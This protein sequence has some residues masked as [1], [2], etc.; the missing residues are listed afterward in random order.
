MVELIPR[1]TGEN[2]NNSKLLLLVHT[3]REN[4]FRYR[5]KFKAIS[6][7]ETPIEPINPILFNG[8]NILFLPC[9]F[10]VGKFNLVIFFSVYQIETWQVI[11]LLDRNQVHYS[12]NRAVRLTE[13]SVCYSEWVNI[14]VS[15]RGFIWGSSH[16]LL[17]SVVIWHSHFG[18]K[19]GCC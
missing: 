7:G 3:R 11:C 5:G 18:E 14:D 10:I 8:L 6:V 12:T 16:I 2:I 9:R 1:E 17:L 15:N 4:Q 19:W 13:L